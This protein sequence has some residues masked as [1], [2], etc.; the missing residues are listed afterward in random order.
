MYTLYVV[1]ISSQRINVKFYIKML[2]LCID[3]YKLAL[4]F[5]LVVQ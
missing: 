2:F 5:K 1:A 4:L 3:I